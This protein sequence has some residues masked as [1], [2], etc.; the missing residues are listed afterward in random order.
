MDLVYRALLL[1]ASDHDEISKMV[2]KQTRQRRQAAKTKP[3][4]RDT[5]AVRDSLR[6]SLLT[7]I[8]G[9]PGS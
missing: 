5:I 6:E 7:N 8:T 2:H 1:I 3:L 4:V 9:T